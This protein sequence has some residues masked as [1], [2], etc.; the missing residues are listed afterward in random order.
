[1]HSQHVVSLPLLCRLWVHSNRLLCQLC[2]RMVCC[3]RAVCPLARGAF[4]GAAAV[5]V[6][7]RGRAGA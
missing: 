2:S 7:G 3:T 1:M 4:G 6:G 5:P